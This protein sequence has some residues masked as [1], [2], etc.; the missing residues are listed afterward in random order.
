MRRLLFER[1]Y[2][3]KQLG[4][5]GLEEEEFKKRTTAVQLALY[6][7]LGGVF[8]CTIYMFLGFPTVVY[9]VAIYVIVSQLNLLLLRVSHNYDRFGLIQLV[10]ILLFP[11]STQLTIGGFIEASGVVLAAFYAPAGALLYSRKEVARLCF[12][13]F[14]IEIVAATAWEY[15]YGSPQPALPRSIILLFF[16]SNSIS[17]FGILYILLESFLKK[18][19]ELRIELRRSLTNLR[20]T[21]AQLIQAEKMASL[22][23]LTAGIAHEIQNPLNFVNN[24]SELN[25]ELA[26]EI[27]DELAKPEADQELIR[28]LVAD[29]LENQGKVVHHGQRAS[30]IIKGMLE[31]SRSGSGKHELA[32]IN[33]LAEEFMHLAYHGQRAKDSTFSVRL[34]TSFQTDLP[35]IKVISQDLGR[36][37]LNLL[38]NAFYAAKKKPAS[39]TYTPTVWLSTEREGATVRIRI[40]DNG[41]GIPEDVLTNIFQ[42]FFTT[43][44]TGEGT[45]LGLSLSYDI[46]TGGHNGSIEVSSTLGT[47]TEF[48]ITLP[49]ITS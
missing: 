42:P 8:F 48:V 31:H 35:P 46:I 45:G 12:Y 40:R 38:S 22:G 23:Q 1:G 16:A 2:F 41:I 14:A 7:A 10:L 37:I 29:L 9:A 21:Q 27:K 17:I 39:E 33:S 32:H 25:T 28:E 43:K 5:E 18:Q 49:A 26:Q 47:G 36:V 3:W 34:V 44:P 6:S 20:T 24:F 13:I 11:L 30:T 19:E 15:Y 4:F